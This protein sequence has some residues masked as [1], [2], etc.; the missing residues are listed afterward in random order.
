MKV[1]LTAKVWNG[2]LAKE[3]GLIDDI[4]FLDSYL[5]SLSAVPTNEIFV[6]TSDNE[7]ESLIKDLM[8]MRIDKL[9]KIF[10]NS[11][12]VQSEIKLL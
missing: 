3:N 1:I 5:E 4:E 10:Y 2:N 9:M 8:N 7:K 12:M 11:F 6:I